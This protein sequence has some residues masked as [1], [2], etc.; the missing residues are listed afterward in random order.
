MLVTGAERELKKGTGHL[1]GVDLYALEGE[2]ESS[3]EAVRRKV[4][5]T[6][7]GIRGKL[8]EGDWRVGHCRRRSTRV[9]SDSTGRRAWAEC[10]QSPF[11]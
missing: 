5:T 7:V 11:G 3:A 10:I 1:F 6:R 4:W 9:A 8:V 2:P